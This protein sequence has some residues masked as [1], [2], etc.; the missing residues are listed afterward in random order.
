MKPPLG[1]EGGGEGAAQS[2]EVAAGLLFTFWFSLWPWSPGLR[3]CIIYI[4]T[5]FI[6]GEYA[7]DIEPLHFVTAA[8][9]TRGGVPWRGARSRLPS[10]ATMGTSQAFLLRPVVFSAWS[11]A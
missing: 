5:I 3:Y 4:I 6:E 11:C 8:V 1:G 2:C 7:L 10:G 9:R